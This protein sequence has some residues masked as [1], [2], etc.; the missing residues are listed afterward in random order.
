MVQPVRIDRKINQGT[1][2]A[3]TLKRSH[4]P[5]PVFRDCEGYRKSCD[6]SPAPEA[7]RVYQD[8]TGCT[9]SAVLKMAPTGGTVIDTLTTANGRVTSDGTNI[10]LHFT[11]AATNA[12]PP[13]VQRCWCY[14]EVT[15][16]N[17]DVERHFEILFAISHWDA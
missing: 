4:F 15:R 3:I 16:P 8:Y 9:F 10:V 5:Y 11:P 7:D 1:T 6:R 17:G 12:Y 2:Q 14:V 13:D